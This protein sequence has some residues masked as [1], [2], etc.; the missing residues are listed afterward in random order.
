MDELARSSIDPT[1]PVVI[2]DLAGLVEAAPDGLLLVD[3]NGVILLVNQ[4]VEELFGYRREDLIGNTVELLLPEAVRGMHRT[5]RQRYRSDP[6][7]RSMGS[8]LDLY[9]QRAD[10][11]RVVVEVSLSPTL[12]AGRPA[13]IAAVRD[14]SARVAADAHTRRIERLIDRAHEGVYLLDPQTLRFTYVNAGAA[15]QSGYGRQALQAMTPLHLMVDMDEAIL[16]RL[17]ERAAAQGRVSPL[18]T[19][20][21]RSDRVDLPVELLLEWD[22]APEGTAAVAVLVRD[23]SERRENEEELEDTRR[24]LALVEERERIARD[25][26]DRVIQRL[27]ATGMSLQATLDRLADEQL[28]SRVGRAVDDLDSTIREI[29][30]VI[31]EL[32]PPDHGESIRRRVLSTAR[33]ARATLGF[34]PVVRFDGPVDSL[35]DPGVAA[36]LL[37]TLQE[38]L[39]N[40]ARHAGATSVTV[41][42]SARAGRITLEI[43]DDGVG[44]GT[45][46]GTGNGLPN[47]ATRAERLGGTF[48][49]VTASPR[50][51]THLR[52]SV[53]ADAS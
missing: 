14:I 29:R 36:E 51:G 20:L 48:E 47:M 23:L 43:V 3:E 8:G 45:V 35:S 7:T 28:S 10:G 42:M 46:G 33:D 13:V 22:A 31:F 19:R 5:H 38:G 39:S 4:Q 24:E 32:Q 50:G 34:E 21:R 6:R 53:P 15:V 52:W 9:G 44:I 37:A 26:H 1:D 41:S 49:V 40:V 11:S 18:V 17:I 2:A 27:F 30:A 16:R 12:H 25:L